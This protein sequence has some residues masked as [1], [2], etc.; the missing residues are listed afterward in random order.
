MQFI[1]TWILRYKLARIFKRAEQA[2]D[3]G[4]QPGDEVFVQLYEQALKLALWHHAQFK[5]FVIAAE[6]PALADLEKLTI[7]PVPVDNTQKA[8]LAVLIAAALPVVLGT[9]TG[10]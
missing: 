1:K 4:R 6:V 9:L 5:D 8:K 3:L 7:K 2:V 10:I